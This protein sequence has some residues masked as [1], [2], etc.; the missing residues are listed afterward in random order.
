MP[1]L[2]ALA[3]LILAATIPAAAGEPGSLK[4]INLD[5]LNTAA[6]E[7]D[8]SPGPDGTRLYYASNAGGDWDIYLSTRSGAA[9]APGKPG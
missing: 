5:K 6:D 1:R 8:P 9:W 3:A 2:T 4:P 7:D